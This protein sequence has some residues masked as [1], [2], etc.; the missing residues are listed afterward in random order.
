MY[1]NYIFDLYGTLVDIH[2]NERKSKLWEKMKEIYGFYGADYTKK[3]LKEAFSKAC[4]Q[5]EE[6]IVGVDFPEIKIEQVFEQL[7]TQKGAAVEAGQLTVICQMFR[8]ISTK[9]IKLYPGV[10]TLLETLKE[11]GKK[12]YVLSNAQEVFTKYEMQYLGLTPY[13][14]GIVLSSEEG[15]AKPDQR[16]YQCI[17]TRYHL[18]VKDSIMI[19]NDPITDIKGAY[20]CG[21]DSLYIHTNLSPGKTDL[22][23]SKYTIMDGDISKM[24]EIIL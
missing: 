17:L 1:Q 4:K 20:K 21:M 15:C 16:F 5:A 9:Y 12:I 2:T 3:E 18:D 8:I 7:F 6:E 23:Y 11:K 13:F 14:D 22:L 19:G 10:I 24:K